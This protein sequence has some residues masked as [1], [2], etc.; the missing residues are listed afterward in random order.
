MSSAEL[1]DALQVLQLFIFGGLGIVAVIHWRRHPG[2][3]SAWLAA[4]FGILGVVV[5]VARFLPEGSDDPTVLWA[6]KAMVA[7]LVLIPYCLFRFMASLIRPI[8]WIWVTAPIVTGA[9]ALG[10]L[11]LPAFPDEGEARPVWYQVYIGALLIQWVFLTGVVAIRLWRAGRGQPI[12]ARRRMRTMS[13]GATG[14]ALALVIGGES[15]NG[16]AT[17]VVVQLLAVGAAPLMLA[18]F[19]P[20]YPLRVAWG[21]QEHA[22]LREARLSLMGATTASDVTMVLLPHART[23]VGAT[24]ALLETMDGEIVASDGLDA[25]EALAVIR[26]LDDGPA[27]EGAGNGSLVRMSMSS[28]QLIIVTN[29]LTP[30]FGEDEIA[31]L[32]ELAVLADLAFG[33]IRLVDNQRR[34]AE[35]VESSDD[36]II[37]QSLDGTIRSWNRGSERIYGYR[38]EE[39]VGKSIS[40]LVPPDIENDVPEI[41]ERV[42][43]GERIEHY[44][45]RRRTKDGRTIDVSLTVSPLRDTDGRITGASAIARNVTELK[46]AS[47]AVRKSEERNR[48]VIN[49]ANDAYIEI[50]SGS[51][52]REWNTAAAEMFGIATADA[53]GRELPELIIPA[54][55]RNAHRAGMAHYL[56]TREGP[57]LNTT[58]EIVALRDQTQE[59]PI[60]LTIWPL[61]VGSEVSFHAFVRD[62]TERKTAVD[63]ITAAKEEADRANR[64]KSEFLSR[65]SHELRT[66]MNAVLGFAQL[67][68]MDLENPQQ[69]ESTAEIIKAGKHLLELID[70]VLD[71]AR[72]EAGKL[73]LSLE[74]VDAVQAVEDC[75][76]LLTPLANGEGVTLSMNRRGPPDRSAYVFADRQ[77]LKQVLLNLISN[78][79]KYNRGA[80]NVRVS[81]ESTKQGRLKIDVADTGHGIPAARIE[82]LFAPFER[83]GAEGSGVQGTGL[84]LA[85]S[86]PLVEAMGGTI[87]VVSEVGTGTTFSV[88][89]ALAQGHPAKD[90]TL[91]EDESRG[92]PM[93]ER[94]APSTTRAILYIEDNLSNLKLVER[95]VARRPSIELIT[96][97]Q[98]SI[99]VTL[100]RD[101]RPDLILLDLNLPDIPGEEVLARLQ[102]D[103]RT[104]ELPIVVISADATRGQVKRLLDAG[105]RTYLTKP[106]DVT[107]FFRIVD[108]F[109]SE[110]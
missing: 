70:E 88:E 104:A 60:E 93:D 85:L 5:V 62:I 24:A 52:V 98:G 77:R 26:S 28:G 31:R 58:I 8:R 20:P 53:L 82:K 56:A 105:A 76:S 12:V 103:P 9:V 44:E 68:D 71:I 17:A 69:K 42:N 47:E 21:R 65:M 75:M 23:F 45:T 79:I 92:I 83:L 15:S 40:M 11:V 109:C 54:R 6:R 50:D 41:L 97:M 36:A 87:S 7:T 99:G 46:R 81:V 102:S 72:I 25:E 101:H 38:S 86:K 55:F 16:D 67:L 100:A 10:A 13:A 49:T 66:P 37:A 19:A 22:A 30:F 14:L 78:G 3:A 27:P 94:T 29:P 73:R 32:E 89:L 18:G 61:G 110:G 4:T 90:H 2:G 39:V 59:F 107:D 74:P 35:I 96:A 57:V 64:A 63:E 95:L 33:R 106:I 43:S 91:E 84:G 108:D 34:L 51:V 1:L 48:A 80:G